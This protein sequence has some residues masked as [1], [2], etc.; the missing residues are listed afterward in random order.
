MTPYTSDSFPQSAP[1]HLAA[2]AHL[3]GLETPEVPGPACS[4][5]AVRQGEPHPFAAAHPQRVSSVSI[6]RRCR[7]TKGAPAYR[8]WARQLEL[9]R[10]IS[11][12]MDLDALGQ[13]DFVIA[14]GVYSWVPAE[15]QDALL[16]AFRRLLASEGVAYVSYNVYPGWKSKEIVRDA[17]LLAS[18][19]SAHRTR[20]CARRAAW[21][22][23][24]GG[25][26]G[27][28][29]AGQRR[30]PNSR[31]RKVSGIPTC[32]TT[33]SRRSTGRAISTRWWD[34]PA[35]MVSPI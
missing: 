13:F 28:R 17:M 9:L 23:P 4:K 31:P 18:G 11:R 24:G 15:V 14:H 19:A 5:S 20:R 35:R 12:R 2:I 21:S 34:V 32:C 30:W 1:G 33:N 22:I 8:P 27:R 3:F 10:A 26:S 6:C 7:S 29:R 16:S 25:G